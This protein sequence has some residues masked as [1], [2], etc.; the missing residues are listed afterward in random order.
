ML[1]CHVWYRD[2]HRVE[3]VMDRFRREVATL[4]EQGWEVQRLS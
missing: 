1:T 4:A 3:R 2:W